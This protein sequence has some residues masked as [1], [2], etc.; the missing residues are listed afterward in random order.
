MRSLQVQE[1]PDPSDRPCQG[2]A[3]APGWSNR[4]GPHTRGEIN[5]S[6]TLTGV[7]GGKGGE[8]TGEK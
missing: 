3:V 8:F 6:N 7:W 4:Q 2:D 1:S 5:Q